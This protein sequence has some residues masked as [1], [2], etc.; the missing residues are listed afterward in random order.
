MNLKIS[1]N[2]IKPQF[3]D[4]LTTMN[5]E[6]PKYYDIFL[7]YH[8]NYHNEAINLHRVLT[9]QGIKVW[10]DLVE[11]KFGDL[12]ESRIE[13]AVRSSYAFVCC[14]NNDYIKSKNCELELR[15]AL[16]ANCKI[17][18]LCLDSSFSNN[19]CS[20]K[21]FANKNVDNF[22]EN[23]L[24]RPCYLEKI[25]INDSSE[26]LFIDHILQNI[27]DNNNFQEFYKNKKINIE[28]TAIK[29]SQFLDSNTKKVKKKNFKF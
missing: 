4:Q 11:I 1:S 15:S 17:F 21:R 12:I 22:Y 29:I 26:N 16:A 6:T 13:Q 28:T 7:S 3:M 5:N 9:N 8:W 27:I 18:V 19:N 20:K 2:E 25:N 10:L 14:Y 23:I 24:N